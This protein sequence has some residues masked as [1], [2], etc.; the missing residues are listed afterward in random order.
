[1]KLSEITKS[2]LPNLSEK[3][4]NI[5]KMPKMLIII[6]IAA[7]IFLAFS[8]F[9]TNNAKTKKT[10]SKT[11]NEIIKPT[12]D[13]YVRN[14]E[15]RLKEVL[16]KINGAGTVTVFIN[17]DSGGEKVLA[18]DKKTKESNTENN[19]NT[20]KNYETEENIV[21]SGQSPEQSPYI[22][23]ELFPKPSGILIIAEGAENDRVKLEIYEAVRAIFGLPANRIKVTS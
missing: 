16:E 4:N 15:K 19:E 18:V 9:G 2:F 8:D 10:E 7:I 23:E 1:M 22:T 6:I 13:E 5:K 14:T 17:S 3:S 20:D 12:S 21:L 11:D